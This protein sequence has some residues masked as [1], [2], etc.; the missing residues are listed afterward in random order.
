MFFNSMAQTKKCAVNSKLTGHNFYIPRSNHRVQARKGFFDFLGARP[1]KITA[2]DTGKE[3]FHLLS[4][5][6]DDFCE[7]VQ[8]FKK[9]RREFI[10]VGG[11]GGSLIFKYPDTYKVEDWM[12]F[13]AS[14]RSGNPQEIPRVDRSDFFKFDLFSDL[15]SSYIREIRQ[16][17][18]STPAIKKTETSP[19]ELRIIQDKKKYGVRKRLFE[20]FEVS[21]GKLRIK[22]G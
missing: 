10:G 7:K 14:Y 6:L 21:E 13:T 11:H 9:I 18:L 19:A 12:M 22:T 4:S 2:F 17:I 20:E 16:R 8:A 15:D 5:S 1:R 3:I